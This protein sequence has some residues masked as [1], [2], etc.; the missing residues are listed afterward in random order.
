M[1]VAGRQ[2]PGVPSAHVIR[3]SFSGD[4]LVE[5]PVVASG[6][7]VPRAAQL[8]AALLPGAKPQSAEPTA[9]WRLID[10]AVLSPPAFATLEEFA[11]AL[12]PFAAHDPQA[13]I[14]DLTSRWADTQP[15]DPAP[16]EPRGE[17]HPAA[18]EPGSAMSVSEMRR[19]RRGTGLSL[20]EVSKRSR[21][22]VSLL[23][24]LE[25][26]Y[27][28]NWP[29]GLYGRTQLVRYA[30]AAG[31]E[32]QLVL[33]AIWPLVLAQAAAPGAPLPSGSVGDPDSNPILIVQPAF[34][35][36]EI[37]FETEDGHQAEVIADTDA[38]AAGSADTLGP[39][40]GLL[41][42]SSHLEAPRRSS[43]AAA[44]AVL[45]LA[46]AGAVWGLRES[47]TDRRGTTPQVVRHV[48]AAAGQSATASDTLSS[49]RPSP[50]P[51][52]LRLGV[53][54]ARVSTAGV[55]PATETRTIATA[56]AGRVVPVES[57]EDD[58]SSSSAAFQSTGGVEFADPIQPA[59]G[60][61]RSGL[62]LRIMRRR[63]RSLAELSHPS[64][65]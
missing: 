55:R 7:P 16:I 50:L 3:L 15:S 22:P 24:Q 54:A 28:R 19:T 61:S 13:A 39:P 20:D 36:D 14:R 37:L 12:A 65:A 11:V 46:T 9:L 62:G 29:Q 49:S 23:R 51:P 57:S 6:E 5:G 26:G 60:E 47:P 58:T 2:L 8:L 10:R 18:D 52:V 38:G 40:A 53:R 44:A 48:P 56:T 35:P 41:D 43:M 42:P 45:A 59:S 63:R 64:I 32:R 34:E 27:L 30:R 25:W 21:I 31:L 17:A 1:Q 4:V 33:D